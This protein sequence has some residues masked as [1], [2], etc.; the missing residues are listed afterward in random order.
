[1][2]V[3]GLVQ[4]I[5]VGWHS[6]QEVLLG[7]GEP[8]ESPIDLKGDILDDVRGVV[9]QAADVQKGGVGL[10]VRLVPPCVEVQCDV[11]EVDNFLVDLGRHLQPVVLVD[12]LDLLPQLLGE[13]V[14]QRADC[15]AVIPVE[16]AVDREVLE[17]VEEEESDEVGTFSSIV[18]PLH[19]L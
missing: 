16:A 1:M 15:Q 10:H 19:Q 4:G 2:L 11:Q 13:A 5:L 7:A 9:G 8:E 14:G 12:L 6:L 17:L 3:A 18:R